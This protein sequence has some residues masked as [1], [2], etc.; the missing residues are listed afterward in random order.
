M[1]VS[2]IGLHASSTKSIPLPRN[3]T[4]SHTPSYEITDWILRVQ[5][6]ENSAKTHLFV[7]P[8]ENVA[9]PV[10]DLIRE[11]AVLK[12]VVKNMWKVYKYDQEYQS[13][14]LGGC[15]EE[16]F[17]GVAETFAAEFDEIPAPQIVYAASFL[18]NFLDESLT[19]ND[20]SVL[21]NVDPYN[22]EKALSPL[23]NVHQVERV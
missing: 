11:N 13:F 7:V 15:S 18:L 22:I 23:Q 16:D 14:L 3:L 19:S 2:K 9:Q 17:M 4:W 20:L 10:R 1:P 5:L 12:N 8:T 6:S 21:V